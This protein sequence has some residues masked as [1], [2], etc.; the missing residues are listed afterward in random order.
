MRV[1]VKTNE[2]LVR[3]GKNV[4]TQ[5][6]GFNLPTPRQNRSFLQISNFDLQKEEK[7]PNGLC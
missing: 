5:T 2:V 3:A 6:A 4:E 7:D 1:V